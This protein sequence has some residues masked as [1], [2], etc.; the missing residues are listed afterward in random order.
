MVLQDLLDFVSVG[1]VGDLFD[2]DAVLAEY[3]SI[4]EAEL[5]TVSYTSCNVNPLQTILDQATSPTVHQLVAA[6]QPVFPQRAPETPA[7]APVGVKTPHRHGSARRR[8]SSPTSDLQSRPGPSTSAATATQPFDPKQHRTDMNRVLCRAET[9]LFLS[10]DAPT[11]ITPDQLAQLGNLTAAEQRQYLKQ[12]KVFA[13]NETLLTI[14]GNYLPH[15][16]RKVGFYPLPVMY[17]QR[18]YAWWC[19]HSTSAGDN[20]AVCG[21]CMGWRDP[22]PCSMQNKCDICMITPKEALDNRYALSVTYKK[23]SKVDRTKRLK[24]DLLPAAAVHQLEA[25]M[26]GSAK[27]MTS[28]VKLFQLA[29]GTN[30]PADQ[31]DHRPFYENPQMVVDMAQAVERTEKIKGNF[32]L[33]S[34]VLPEWLQVHQEACQLASDEDAALPILDLYNVRS[35]VLSPNRIPD[36]RS[37]AQ[38]IDSSDSDQII[39]LSSGNESMKSPPRV[40]RVVPARQAAAANAAALATN[41]APPRTPSARGTTATKTVALVTKPAPPGTPPI[42]QAAATTA[43]AVV[44]TVVPGE[45]PK[46]K[47]LKEAKKKSRKLS[48]LD[49]T[50]RPRKKSRPERV[51]VQVAKNVLD[52]S[53][54][55][56]SA[57]SSP[58]HMFDAKNQLRTIDVHG[59]AVPP[60][61]FTRPAA[62]AASVALVSPP[63]LI[64]HDVSHPQE[65]VEA[66][67][68][69]PRT[70]GALPDTPT[71][72]H[73]KAT[74]ARHGGVLNLETTAPPQLPPTLRRED[75]SSLQLMAAPPVTPPKPISVVSS[76]QS[77]PT[78]AAGRLTVRA[79]A[80]LET[81]AG[82]AHVSDVEGF[83][84]NARNII[85]SPTP[86]LTSSG[87]AA[88]N[89][90]LD[91]SFQAE[92][93]QQ[94]VVNIEMEVD[95]EPKVDEPGPEDEEAVMEAAD[96]AGTQIQDDSQAPKLIDAIASSPALGTPCSVEGDMRHIL[97][98]TKAGGYW[99][100][101]YEDNRRQFFTTDNNGVPVIL[102]STV[103]AGMHPGPDDII[104]PLPHPAESPAA[105]DQDRVNISSDYS[106]SPERQADEQAM[107]DAPTQE[108]AGEGNQSRLDSTHSAAPDT[109]IPVRDGVSVSLDATDDAAST[110]GP[111]EVTTP[112]SLVVIHR[113]QAL[114][115]LNEGTTTLTEGRDASPRRSMDVTATRDEGETMELSNPQGVTRQEAAT[116]SADVIANR[117]DCPPGPPMVDT[118][119]NA[120]ESRQ[121]PTLD[122]VRQARL[123]MESPAHTR[124]PQSHTADLDKSLSHS[125]TTIRDLP[126]SDDFPEEY[127]AHWNAPA[128][129]LCSIAEGSHARASTHLEV[130]QACRAPMGVALRTPMVTEMFQVR[131]SEECKRLSLLQEAGSEDE[132]LY[133]YAV[134]RELALNAG[135]YEKYY[136]DVQSQAAQYPDPLLWRHRLTGAITERLTIQL[137]DDRARVLE[138]LARAIV[139]QLVGIETGITKLRTML[140]LIEGNHDVKRQIFQEALPALVTPLVDAAAHSVELFH[141]IAQGRRQAVLQACRAG[142]QDCLLALSSSLTSGPRM[143]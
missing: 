84:T 68:L 22:N 40:L 100:Q 134:S 50:K 6:G 101:F 4:F 43:A 122:S 81:G 48:K 96:D 14:R 119:A 19:M 13:G 3:E 75:G 127:A 42:H 114:R 18:F 97:Y 24:K 137:G 125:T 138:E 99:G 41:P 32:V 9:E 141:Q 112:V 110:G 143:F 80:S 7:E 45:T 36:L 31:F 33:D 53:C 64:R 65:A 56:T 69:S 28:I 139:K 88:A 44:D 2:V 104:L 135:D 52:S 17:R 63:R 128:L 120:S 38:E 83:N 116:P 124:S 61:P 77:T 1:S 60:S 29:V 47:K 85:Q 62:A 66:V 35:K 131:R 16:L 130:H 87:I 5:P 67:T 59:E 10:F 95:K 136:P 12:F 55:T 98:Y 86:S 109:P 102:I 90:L 129:P 25:M 89:T 92:G 126:R 133:G 39:D 113:P 94:Q 142:V 30:T 27:S 115:P 93:D 121:Q 91:T 79:E 20:H 57:S 21:R 37:I 11:K 82:S 105:R 71:S 74:S 23:L 70:T 15:L 8:Q 58:V 123:Q 72:P 111:P 118:P 51:V 34:T 107:D 54:M 106:Q 46:P 108:A 140:D 73:L 76:V 132:L 78:Q 117:V 49:D 26:W 103:P